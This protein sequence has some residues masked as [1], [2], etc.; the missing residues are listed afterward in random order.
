MDGIILDLRG[1]F[2]G[3]WYEYLDPFFPNRN[4]FFEYTWIDRDGE[5]KLNTPQP[6]DNKIHFSGPMVVLIN[7]G[8]RSGKEA[9]AYQFKKSNRAI[10]I[11]TN[12]KG[13][14]TAGRGIFNEEILPYFLYLATGELLLDGTK[15]E[16]FGISPDIY[17]PY[18]LRDSVPEDPQ[19]NTA[20]LEIT[21]RIKNKVE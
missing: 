3:A 21:K 1:G 19:L 18:S 8:V 13:A 7:E 16:G 2:G 11:G 14:F 5:S 12:T 6:Q 10:L 4:E 20:I 15:V 9:L 17:V